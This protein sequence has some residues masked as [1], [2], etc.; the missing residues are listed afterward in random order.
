VCVCIINPRNIYIYIYI[1]SFIVII[2]VV[3]FNI[4][5]KNN[6]NNN[7]YQKKKFTNYLSK[8]NI[9]ITYQKIIVAVVFVSIMIICL[10]ISVHI[11]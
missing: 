8:K 4:S 11:A 3:V 7:T 10:K 6:N 2:V 1:I 5:I 9:S